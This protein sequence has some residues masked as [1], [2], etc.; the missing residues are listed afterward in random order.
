MQAVT[1]SQLFDLELPG[2]PIFVCAGTLAP[3]PQGRVRVVSGRGFSRTEAR[4]RCFAEGAE[5]NLAVWNTDRPVLRTPFCEVAAAAVDPRQLV[6]LSEAQYARREA[7]NASAP[8]DHHWPAPINPDQPLDWVEAQSLSG[9]EPK[10]VP[11]AYCFLGHPGALEQGFPVPDSSGLA[12]GRDVGDA[13]ARAALEL[14]E[15]DA[16][17]VWWYN[18]VKRPPLDFDR[19]QLPWLAS[20]ERYISALGQRFWVLD[21]THDLG[22]PVAAAISSGPDGRDLAL[23]FA[24]GWTAEEAATG[25][26]SELVQ[27]ELSKRLQKTTGGHDLVSLARTCSLDDFGFFVPDPQATRV[28]PSQWMPKEVFHALAEQGY[29][30]FYYDFSRHGGAAVR[31]IVP[32]FRPLWPRFAPGRLSDVPHRLGWTATPK[33]EAL[34]NP[35]PILY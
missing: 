26:V 22:V 11:A 8:Q 30:A 31:V 12:A 3:D 6:L 19:E 32:R 17:A 21:L 27:F 35:V 33:P 1:F 34:F 16:V 10:L 15:R 18:R 13:A 25:A 20:F 7:W 28:K 5:R 24:A 14:V 29:P 9:G 4:E 23:G 2:C